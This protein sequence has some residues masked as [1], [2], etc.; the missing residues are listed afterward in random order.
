[1]N[2]RG[3]REGE[4][5]RRWTPVLSTVPQPALCSHNSEN[6]H[7]VLFRWL[8][9]GR[10]KLIRQACIF[11]GQ[12]M[13]HQAGSHM[14][15]H[16]FELLCGSA[17]SLAVVLKLLHT[18]TGAACMCAHGSLVQPDLCCSG[19]RWKQPGTNGYE[20]AP[21]ENRWVL[22]RCE[23]WKVGVMD[24][25]YQFLQL[26]FCCQQ[27]FKRDPSGRLWWLVFKK[28]KLWC[29][30]VKDW[31]ETPR[32][33]RKVILCIRRGWKRCWASLCGAAREINKRIIMRGYSGINHEL[34]LMPTW[35][36]DNLHNDSLLWRRTWK[37]SGWV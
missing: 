6:I 36:P 34:A 31:E 28:I 27:N 2:C 20:S 15:T 7:N 16:T 14:L 35:D 22:E 10:T 21:H 32:L 12:W 4:G 11:P 18:C 8:R 1:M 13:H 37:P 25:K 26:Y 17:G 9:A 5:E 3:L 33:E 24:C 19:Y 23:T 29:T 30:I